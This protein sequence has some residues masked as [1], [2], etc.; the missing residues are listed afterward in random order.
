MMGKNT[1]LLDSG[2]CP[3]SYRD[4]PGCGVPL[5]TLAEILDSLIPDSSYKDI[6]F[7]RSQPY[8]TGTNLLSLNIS[9]GLKYMPLKEKQQQVERN[10]VPAKLY[11]EA[12][13]KFFK[14]N[15]KDFEMKPNW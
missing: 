4:P 11:E 3:D 6:C 13:I 1:N 10:P 8:R 5:L 12:F 15:H 7:R 14:C 9:Y 2:C